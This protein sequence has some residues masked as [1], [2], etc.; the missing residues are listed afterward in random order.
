MLEGLEAHG[1]ITK[2]YFLDIPYGSKKE[3]IND[4][5][6]LCFDYPQNADLHDLRFFMF[7]YV[8]YWLK[9]F[10]AKLILA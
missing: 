5:M 7:V 10:I 2:T 9:Q 6:G 4:F 1:P 8:G 3:D